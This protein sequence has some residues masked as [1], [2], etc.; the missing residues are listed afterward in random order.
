LTI[1]D[2]DLRWND[3]TLHY[4]FGTPDWSEFYE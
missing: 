4:D 3:S 1:P 2:P